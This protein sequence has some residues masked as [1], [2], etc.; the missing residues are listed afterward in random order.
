MSR[1][2]KSYS[3]K[4]AF[5]VVQEPLD[6]GEY[7]L[8]KTATSSYC[9]PNVCHPNK[10][11]SSQSNLLMLKSANILKFNP[12]ARGFDKTSL[13]INLYTKLDLKE[14]VP[15]RDLSGNHPVAITTQVPY[16]NP[17][18]PTYSNYNIDPS[19]ALFGNTTCGINNFVD[20]M[21]YDCPN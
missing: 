5:G 3:G 12:Y 9:T 17:K 13:Y 19:G 18:N 16:I 6:A 15:I 14:V 4:S 21:V 2:F 10:N 7:I 20:Y 11:V 8:S 1:P